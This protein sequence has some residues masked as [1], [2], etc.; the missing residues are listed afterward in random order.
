MFT[1]QG[2]ENGIHNVDVADIERFHLEN[3]TRFIFENGSA[4]ILWF[5]KGFHH[6]S[7]SIRP[8]IE[9]NS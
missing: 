7:G 2:G 5:T 8:A 1:L 3:G 6:F 9:M 4:N